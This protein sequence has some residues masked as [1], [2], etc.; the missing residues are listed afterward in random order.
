MTRS[1]SLLVGAS[2]TLLLA[3]DAVPS[4]QSQPTAPQGL[5]VGR[6]ID[7]G[8]DAGVSGAA[9]TVT[10]PPPA[11]QPPGP[12]PQ[13]PAILTDADGRFVLFPLPAGRINLSVSSRGYLQQ[14]FG[15]LRPGGIAQP[16]ELAPGEKLTNVVVRIWKG[17]TITGR[18]LDDDGEPVEGANIGVLR[19]EITGGR[20]RYTTAGAGQSDD[21]GVY[22]STGLP[23]GKYVV[24]IAAPLTTVP[25]S[26]M[27]LIAD[28]QS[29]SQADQLAL[30]RTLRASDP[31]FL[32]EIG[33]RVGDL[34]LAPPP[35]GTTLNSVPDASG[36]FM[37]VGSTFYPAAS[38]PD[39]AE[40]LT[41]A[42]GELRPGVDFHLRMVPA[43]SISGVVTRADGGSTAH[44]G[45]RLGLESLGHLGTFFALETGATMTDASGRFT[46]LGVPRGSY[47][48]RARV[49]PAP[50]SP[51]A[52]AGPVVAAVVPVPVGDT[53]VR[54]ITVSLVEAP[55]VTGR[56]EFE[57]AT[58][59]TAA[60]I[61]RL[62]I[63]VQTVDLR[64]P[65]TPPAPRS[66]VTATGEFQ[67]GGVTAGS[68]V[69]GATGLP[70]WTVKSAM[71]GGQDLSDQPFE[72][73][74]DVTGVVV[75]LTD[76]V[77][78]VSGVVT[79]PAGGPDSDAAVLA[80]PFDPTR[81]GVR[82][83]R[84][85]RVN[86]K[87]AYTIQ[88]LPAGDYVF[89]AIDDRYAAD[90]EEPAFLNAL[91]RLGTRVTVPNSGAIT[92]DLRTSTIRREQP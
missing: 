44:L 7:A 82:R 10:I 40:V 75:T 29:A 9:V 66:Q 83:R 32:G 77:T 13:R 85:A 26:A 90:W 58:P 4:A 71:T 79:R 76:R 65:S 28:A 52:E 19:R 72:P 8:T 38:S 23:P 36:R 61:A 14:P 74:A 37:V 22:K 91:V 34:Y 47:L 15:A 20:L 55:R 5:I 81:A 67:T 6:V 51:G 54:D 53:P 35:G 48:I 24:V 84:F 43:A 50:A 16:L 60:Q 88:G 46:L 12:Q 45:V 92:V 1:G 21:R 30:N 87:G 63:E 68:Y 31:P 80:F 78:T 2:L 17:A 49:I 42:P 73:T 64:Y 70:G 27:D 69:I 25:R 57:S 62:A 18:I 89:V 56:V 86:S 11:G 39:E 3:S 41:I 59:P 33:Y